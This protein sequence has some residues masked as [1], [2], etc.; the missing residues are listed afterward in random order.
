MFHVHALNLEHAQYAL[1][2]YENAYWLEWIS[3][4]TEGCSVHMLFVIFSFKVRGV[5]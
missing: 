5:K 2:F 4:P 3:M 1:W